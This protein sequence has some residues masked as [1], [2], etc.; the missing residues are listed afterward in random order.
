[1]ACNPNEEVNH[2][3]IKGTKR[4]KA[5]N[6]AKLTLTS[7][8]LAA[9]LGLGLSLWT[10]PAQ[11][12]SC[13]H[14]GQE[15]E[16]CNRGGDEDATLFTVSLDKLTVAGSPLFTDEC[17]GSTDRVAASGLSVQMFFRDGC[18]VT[19]L[20]DRPPLPSPMTLYPF[21]LDVKTKGSGVTEIR[22]YFTSSEF[23][24]I[25][26]PCG[27]GTIWVTDRL[28]AEISSEPTTGEIV[29]E[30]MLDNAGELLTKISQPERRAVT[31]D[32]VWFGTF[33][34]TPVE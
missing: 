3:T 29:L 5:M 23:V 27:G 21:A 17:I 2:D 24:G 16:H 18:S 33:R 10:T 30:P 19:M 6:A 4:G 28:F 14:H 8:I 31:T 32:R 9:A 12:H 26:N 15:E 13:K 34:Y 1:M 20:V 7:T 25:C 11:S 22:L